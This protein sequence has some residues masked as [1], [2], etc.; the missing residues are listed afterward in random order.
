MSKKYYVTTPIYYIND[1]PHIGH[2]Y[3]TVAADILA[4]Y[5]RSLGH[6]TVFST[7]TDENSSKTSVAAGNNQDV[8]KYADDMAGKWEETWKNLGLSFDVFVRTTSKQHKTAVGRFFNKVY[9]KGDIY[10]GKY[11]GLYCGGCEAFVTKRDLDEEGL[12]PDH[13]QKPET[14]SEENYF[15]KLSN[16][17]EALLNHY[18]KNPDF[19]QPDSIRREIINFV[20]DHATDFSISR[21]GLDWGIPLPLDKTQTIYVWFDA[22]INYLSAIGFGI[23]EKKFVKYWPADVHIVGKDIIKFHCAY[24][25]AMLLSAGIELPHQVFA[26]GFFTINGNKISKSLGN[27][28]DPIKLRDEYGF[29]AIR[30]FLFSEFP[31]G[32][33][34]NFSEERLR[35]RYNS[36]LAN[37]LGNLVARVAKLCEKSEFQ[38]HTTSFTIKDAPKEYHEALEHLRFHEALGLIWDYISTIDRQISEEHTWKLSGT[39]LKNALEPKVEK[40]REI[41]ILI[42]PFLPETAPIIQQHF[43]GPLIGAIDPLFPR[44]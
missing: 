36:Q 44:K 17:R 31:F 2:T 41:S 22:L 12:C 3:T 6:D 11:E 34:G 8:Q 21:Q 38:F 4:R 27:A 33:D 30:Y 43:K 28:I 32:A 9:E 35:E 10:E 19:I 5:H 40:I 7:G 15:F 18:E 26:H 20:R 14:V 39:A 23:E 16:Y 1:K 25:P 13:K 37:G 24:W 42:E 29:D